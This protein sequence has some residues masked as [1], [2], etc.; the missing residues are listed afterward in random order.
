MRIL[1]FLEWLGGLRWYVRIPVIAAAVGAGI[2]LALAL[3]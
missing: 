3:G 1:H 2:L